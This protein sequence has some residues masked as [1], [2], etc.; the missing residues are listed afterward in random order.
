[1]IALVVL[2]LLALA[3]TGVVIQTGRGDDLSQLLFPKDE[4]EETDS[5]AGGSEEDSSV[6]VEIERADQQERE[7]ARLRLLAETKAES[8]TLEEKVG[9]LFLGRY[10]GWDQAVRDAEAYHLGGY[11]LFAADFSGLSADEVRQKIDDAQAAASIPLIMAV[12][13]EGGTVV[14]VSQYF[15]DYAFQSPRDIFAEGGYEAIELDTQEKCELLLSLHL[16]V[17]LAPVCDLSDNPSDF[18]YERAFS[19]D[20]ESAS[21]F[22]RRVVSIMNEYGVGSSLKHFPGYG[23]NLDTHV[24][25]SV[26]SRKASEFYDNDLKV[27]EAGIEAGAG[28]VLVSHNIVNCFD[29]E[30]PASLSPAVHELLR[31]ELDFDGVIMTDDLAMDAISVSLGLE[32]GEIAVRA[33]EAGNDLLISSD[34]ET[35]YAA[36]LRAVQ[37]GRLSEEAITESVVRVLIYKEKLGLLS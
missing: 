34:Y 36:V 12:D 7:E 28:A 14:R 19:G 6:S 24:G 15:R 5:T 31:E 21:E 4:S 27:F 26:D 20:A 17:N 3:L 18:M 9:Q 25:T 37:D 22:V 23:A 1:M 8:M 10:P 29:A 30:N 2:F 32:A 16:N 33:V 11:V 35:Q 13:E